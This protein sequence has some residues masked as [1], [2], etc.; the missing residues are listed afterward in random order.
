MKV[1]FIRALTFAIALAMA[2]GAFAQETLVSVSPMVGFPLTPEDLYVIEAG[3]SLTLRIDPVFQNLEGDA[4]LAYSNLVIKSNLGNVS[5]VK[6]DGG[7]M[8]PLLKTTS[9]QVGPVLL[10]GAYGAFKADATPLFNPMIEGALRA[11]LKLGNLRL[12]LEPGIE[13]LTA[14]KDGAFRP[15]LTSI[16]LPVSVTFM[17]GV[18][19]HRALL[20]IGEPE[21][22]PV[23]PV[24]Y[25]SY[26]TMPLGSMTVENKERTAITNVSITFFVP[27]YMDG[28]QTVATFPSLKAG[29]KKDIP[30][31]GLLK[32]TVLGIT[33][34]DTAQA[35]IKV[36]YAI[37]KGSYSVDRDGVLNI[38]GRNA[39]V[40]YDDRIAAAF[41]T[42]KDPTILKLARNAVAGIP[43]TD[44]S[45]PSEAFK[46]A[47]ILF[48]SL[49]AYGLAYVV[50]PKGSYATM[51][52]HAETVDYLQF[53]AETLTYKSGDCDDLA[54]LYLALLE[55]V[56]V[57]TAFITVPGHIYSAFA[58]EGSAQSAKN[59]FASGQDVII[60]DDKAWIP[61]ETTALGKGFA[62][63]WSMGA[64]EWREAERQGAA[65]LVGVHEAWKAYEPSFISSSE[66]KDITEKFP[67]P[68]VV[69]KAYGP[70]MQATASKQLD[71]I[72]QA[73]S[74]GK[75]MSKLTPA[76]KNKIGAAYARYGVMDKAEAA[77]KDAATAALPAALINLG[78]IRFVK[79]DFSGAADFYRQALTA[80]VSN[81]D[82]ALGLSRSLFEASRYDEATTA[83]RQAQSLA[84]EKAAGYAYLAGGAEQATARAADA[85]ARASVDWSY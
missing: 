76:E 28:P 5:I 65:A 81:G 6:A 67:K 2:A 70:M 58:L 55:S 33:E 84:P 30:I 12:G 63:A 75:P 53:P 7:C 1:S 31:T 51:K 50:D 80:Q 15:F 14:T 11:E 3:G 48:Q 61:V 73:L 17:P 41:V 34:T 77:F 79:K 85:E 45:I 25:K 39:I 68:P 43:K 66:N 82:A 9:F 71:G 19:G 21:L 78:N 22:D 16:N 13:I 44:L 10:A 49:E 23:F 60:R 62:E 72:I 36:K 83:Y 18:T 64:R 29:E 4:R 32:N 52:D 57:E 37:G 40:W 26:A 24:I 20:K 46:K 35:Q 56:G 8:L 74:G 38:Q 47:G 54:T 27:A 59:M 69:A 42:A